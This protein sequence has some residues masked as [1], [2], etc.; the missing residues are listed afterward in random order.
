MT[1]RAI[2]ATARTGG[3]GGGAPLTNLNQRRGRRRRG[4]GRRRRRRQRLGGVHWRRPPQARR[5]VRR[6]ARRGAAG[7]GW[8]DGPVDSIKNPELKARSVS[9]L[10]TKM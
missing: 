3:Y 10:E 5:R 8:G 2:S 4:Q 7:P 9:V 1:W 6:R